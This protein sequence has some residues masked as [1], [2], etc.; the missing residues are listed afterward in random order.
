MSRRTWFKDASSAS[1]GMVYA[2]AGW[3]TTPI[4]TNPSLATAFGFGGQVGPDLA[5]TGAANSGPSFIAS[6]TKTANNGEYLVT[7]ADGYRKLWGVE[8]NL[9]GVSAGPAD[10]AWAQACAPVNEGAGHTT[11]ITFLI[12]TMNAAGV[13]TEFTGRTLMIALALKDSGVGA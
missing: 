1:P 7:L 4:G 2:N 12:T 5:G 10:G 11:P 13:P 3:L 6:V 8:G 9:L